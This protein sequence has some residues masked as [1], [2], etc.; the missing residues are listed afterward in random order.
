MVLCQL[1]VLLSLEYRL[2]LFVNFSRC[3]GILIIYVIP[4][5]HHSIIIVVIIALC[6]CNHL[7]ELVVIL[8]EHTGP[9]VGVGSIHDK[10]GICLHLFLQHVLSGL[11]E[12][13]YLTRDADDRQ[14][15]VSLL[16][17]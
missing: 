15:L 3:Y 11:Y 13:V 1:G 17:H 5:S 9:L 16:N 7:I 6:V 14:I 4:I 8:V 2:H 12:L 10:H